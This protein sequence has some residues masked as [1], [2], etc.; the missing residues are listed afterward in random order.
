MRGINERFIDD[1]KNGEL[2]FFG[3]LSIK[4]PDICL[5]IRKNYINLYYK[6]GNAVRITQKRDGYSF[7]FDAR[8]CLNKNDD[9]NYE[10]L[11]SLDKRSIQDYVQAFPTILNELD[12]FF[13]AHSKQ[14]RIYQHNLIKTNQNDLVV[15]DIEYAGWTRDKRLFRLD[16]IGVLRLE[17]GYKLVIFENKYGTGSIGGQAGIKKH[18]DD[19]VDILDFQPSRDE[20][21]QSVINISQNKSDLGLLNLRLNKDDI[22]E[23]EI[24]FVIA[25]FNPKSKSI[26][27]AIET[28]KQTIPAKIIYLNPD[29]TRIDYKR[30][31][32]L[33]E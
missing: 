24:L 23:V 21:I 26:S 8:Y 5:E 31:M 19:I 16:M 14:E 17:E 9:R 1:L 11:S 20:L 29:E 18:Y 12:S 32:D 10:Y 6:G 2:R 30:A 4:N 13:L 28:I 7:E 22:K 25:G 3:E 27:N 33:F 15:L